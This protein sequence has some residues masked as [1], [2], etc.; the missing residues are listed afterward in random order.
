[1]TLAIRCDYCGVST[2]INDTQ[3]NEIPKNWIRVSIKK[4]EWLI[5]IYDLCSRACVAGKA[6]EL[7]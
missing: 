1:M 4:D 6:K 3:T 7:Y 5:D 2:A